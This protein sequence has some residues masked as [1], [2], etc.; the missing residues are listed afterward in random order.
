MNEESIAKA[1]FELEG[2]SYKGRVLAINVDI[3]K[4]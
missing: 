2:L 1:K 4:E 3:K